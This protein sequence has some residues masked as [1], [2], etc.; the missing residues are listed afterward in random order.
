M[1]FLTELKRLNAAIPAEKHAL[2]RFRFNQM[3]DALLAN[4]AEAIA[5]LVEA[6]ERLDVEYPTSRD[7]MDGVLLPVGVKGIRYAL[8]KLEKVKP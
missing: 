8:A 2:A 1:T 3:R 4:N 5:E 6:A 7:G